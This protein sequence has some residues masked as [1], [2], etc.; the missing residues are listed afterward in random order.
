MPQPHPAVDVLDQRASRA[1]GEAARRAVFG[2]ERSTAAALNPVLQ[3][4][5]AVA[6]PGPELAAP[7]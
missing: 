2:E 4:A 7:P 6:E 3:G 5:A 1:D